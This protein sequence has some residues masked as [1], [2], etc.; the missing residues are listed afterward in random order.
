MNTMRTTTYWTTAIALITFSHAA[1]A[2]AP[3]LDCYAERDT[4]KCEAG[5][6]DGSAATGRKISVRGPDGKV[7]LESALDQN[8]AFVFTPPA[9]DYTVVFQGGNGHDATFPSADIAK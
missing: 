8:N 5:F 6:S 3:V 4:V 1:A 7:L 2:H 9:G